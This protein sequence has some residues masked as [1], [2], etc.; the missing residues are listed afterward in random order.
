M[1]PGDKVL[2]A[3][4]RGMVG[5]AISQ[6]FRAAES[7]NLLVPSR[8][9]LDLRDQVATA[10]SFG[11]HRPE[12]VIIAAAKVGGIHANDTLPAGF[13]AG[14]LAIAHSACARADGR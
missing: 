8:A 2:I 11:A 14:N 12:A 4:A 7:I 9:E 5:S 3:G 10:H 1:T 13:L 6:W